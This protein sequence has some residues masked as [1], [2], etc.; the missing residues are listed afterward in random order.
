MGQYGQHQEL[1]VVRCNDR[2]HIKC[3]PQ[4]LRSG[5]DSGAIKRKFLIH[6]QSTSTHCVHTST[7]N[8]QH[9]PHIQMG[10]SEIIPI[11]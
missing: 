5:C 10:K 3:C 6:G 11:T 8:S 1:G 4:E 9:H 7:S 2:G